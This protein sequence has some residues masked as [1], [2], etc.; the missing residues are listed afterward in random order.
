[1]TLIVF[2]KIW[3]LNFVV[4]ITGLLSSCWLK[5]FNDFY[6]TCVD[7]CCHMGH[8]ILYI[9]IIIIF[10]YMPNSFIYKYCT[11]KW[12]GFYLTH[13]SLFKVKDW[14][15][16]YSHIDNLDLKKKKLYFQCIFY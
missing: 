16:I 3:T 6:E 8:I 10:W 13:I 9:I 2:L 5:K 14:T 4:S 11:E 15:Y 7:L 1:M 12:S